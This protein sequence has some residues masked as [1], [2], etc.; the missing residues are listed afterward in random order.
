MTEPLLRVRDLV[1]EFPLSRG[2]LRAVDGVSFD[3]LPGDALG[4]VGESGSGKT[5]ALRALL[6]L[7]P[8]NARVSGSSIQLDGQEML[9]ASEERLRELRGRSVSMVFQEPMT[10]LNPVVT[11]GEQIG[12]AP[13]VRLGLGRR[14]ARARAIELMRLVGI[15]DPV[16]RARAYPHELSGG[17]R[18]RVMIAIALS[19]DPRLLIADEPTT[20]LDATI[21]AQIIDQLRVLRQRT[22]MAVLF[23]THDLGLVADFADRVL[24]MYAGRIVEAGPVATLFAA[25]RMPYTRGLMR[26]RPR[27][28]AR[29]RIEPIRGNAPDPMVLPSGC[30]FQPRCDHWL[31]GICDVALPEL[32]AC[33]TDHEVRCRRWKDLPA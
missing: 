4:I 18:Q 28:G 7:L 29:G 31:P 1:V 25:A 13:L 15:P 14:A 23:I 22:G 3:V 10:A 30:A 27:I 26:S 24:V 20:A 33:A 9:G 12:E 11:V 5:M 32:E 21:Q 19:C 6:G 16:R 8:R 2:V 17:M